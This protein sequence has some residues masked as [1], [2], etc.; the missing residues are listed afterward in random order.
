[1]AF[2]PRK[3]TNLVIGLQTE[4]GTEAAGDL[5]KIPLP[6]GCKPPTVNPNYNFFQYG[7]GN[8]N[9]LQYET[10]GVTVEG[11]MT[12]PLVPGYVAPG[13]TNPFG[14]WIWGRAEVEDYYEGYYATVYVDRGNDLVEKFLDV[15]VKSGSAKVDYGANYAALDLQIEGLAMPASDTFT[16][17]APDLFEV[18]PYRFSEATISVDLGSGYAAESY[19]RNH[20]LDFDNMC[21]KIEAVNGTVTA[22]AMPNSELAQWK[23]SF[24]RAFFDADIYDAFIA[25]TEF[26]YKLVLAR[27]GVATATFEFPRCVLTGHSLDIPDKGMMKETGI[28]WQALGALDNSADSFTI[29]ETLSS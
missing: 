29:T 12:L 14:Q 1:M 5:V 27:A 21:E 10:G 8:Y 18:R 15:K 2:V 4:K 6:E 23:G 9:L 22:A 13:V 20:S 28:G 19:S 11:S 16:D 17:P 24:D 25:G 26:A 3:A 7:G